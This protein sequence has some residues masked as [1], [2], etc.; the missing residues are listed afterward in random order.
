MIVAYGTTVG[1]GQ[2]SCLFCA[3]K[4]GMPAG[5]SSVISQ[6]QAFVTIVFAAILFQ[7]K[8]KPSQVV[9]LVLLLVD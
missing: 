9:G 5:I 1:I 8:I 2:F 4:M 7:E 6:V 3:I